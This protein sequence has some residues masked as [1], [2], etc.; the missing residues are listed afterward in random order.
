Q[1]PAEIAEFGRVKYLVARRAARERA[2]EVC[3][4]FAMWTAETG[5]S[6]EA[7]LSRSGRKKIKSAL[8]RELERFDK[9]LQ[10]VHKKIYV[11]KFRSRSS[12]DLDTDFAEAKIAPI[13][14]ETLAAGCDFLVRAYSAYRHSL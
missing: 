5:L 4:D 12:G 10:N 9:Q 7:L 14:V 3:K 1:L 11:G 13:L 2:D 6:R 8:G